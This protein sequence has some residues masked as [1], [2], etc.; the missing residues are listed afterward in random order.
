MKLRARVAGILERID[1]LTLRERLFVFAAVLMVASALWESLFYGPLNSRTE[2]TR[3][4]IAASAQRLAQLEEAI[5]VAAAGLDG[6]AGN[7]LQRLQSLREAVEAREEELRIF[8]SDLVDP[9]QMRLVVED[10]IERQR[11]LE[12][13]RTSN[14][15]AR[16]LLPAADGADTASAPE[17]NLYRHGLLI[18]LEGS[19]LDLLEY[20]EAVERLP[21]RIFWGRLELATLEHPKL[22]IRL[23]LNTLSLEPEWIGV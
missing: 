21:W 18:E 16:P 23:E 17:P 4:T 20:L 9:A 12:L 13:I 14:V 11:G 8:T 3:A 5:A 6:G 7:S 10:L 1:A 2:A 19:Y 22:R 15:G